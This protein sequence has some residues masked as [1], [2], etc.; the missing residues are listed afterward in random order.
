M[1]DGVVPHVGGPIIGPGAPTILLDGLPASCMGDTAVCVGPPA[2]VID[3]SLTVL[4]EGRPAAR[5]GDP[6]DHGGAITLGVPNVM[7]GG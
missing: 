6:T 3:G 2:T 7:I 1:V 4:F 5:M